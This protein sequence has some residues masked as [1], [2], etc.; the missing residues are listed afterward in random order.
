MISPKIRRFVFFS[1]RFWSMAKQRRFCFDFST[2]QRTRTT[3]RCSV[4]REKFRTFLLL[5][6]YTLASKMSDIH[7]G[8]AHLVALEDCGTEENDSTFDHYVAL[9]VAQHRN[10]FD[11]KALDSSLRALAKTAEQLKATVHL[12]RIGVGSRGFNWYGTEKL[13]KKYLSS[14]S[15]PTYI[16]YFKRNQEK[17]HFDEGKSI[18][19]ENDSELCSF[20]SFKL[21]MMKNLC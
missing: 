10:K 20:L 14:R 8:D 11:F 12:P 6:R 16:Y 18:S 9:I 2:F 21:K 7:L 5:V 13:I 15:I 17:R 4:S 1:R 19:L 3:V